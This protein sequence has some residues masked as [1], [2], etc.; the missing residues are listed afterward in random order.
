MWCVCGKTCKRKE[1]GFI[2]R[3]MLFWYWMQFVWVYEHLK[4]GKKTKFR[5]GLFSALKDFDA[6]LSGMY[7]IWFDFW[8]IFKKKI[9]FFRYQWGSDQPEFVSK[10]WVAL[11]FYINL[12]SLLLSWFCSTVIIFYTDNLLDMI[13]NSVAVLFI[14]QIDDDIVT[15]SDYENILKTMAAYS[16]QNLASKWLDKLAAALLKIQLLW[17]KPKVCTFVITPLTVLP[18][19]ITILCYDSNQCAPAAWFVFVCVF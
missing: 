14:I 11:G 17:S 9:C 6:Y 19:I 2:K 3:W 5:L 7:A 12:F 4:V 1:V 10:I 13:L 15:F 16:S 8:H 18:P